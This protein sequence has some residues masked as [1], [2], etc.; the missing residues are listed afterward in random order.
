[1]PGLP[2]S[3]LF[4]VSMG[5]DAVCDCGAD[6]ETQYCLAYGKKD[7]SRLAAAAKDSR[8][9]GDKAPDVA[10]GSCIAGRIA[11]KNLFVMEVMKHS[12]IKW[13][14]VTD[15][16]KCEDCGEPILFGVHAHFHAAS[17]RAICGSC[18]VRRGWSDSKV[19]KDSVVIFEQKETLKALRRR[20]GLEKQEL[21]VLE[22]KKELHKIGE[23]Y[24]G[25]GAELAKSI[26][27][28]NSFVDSLATPQEKQVLVD[29]KGGVLFG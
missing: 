10:C 6:A 1:M 22:G 9:A 17:G 26:G 25:L 23:G 19:A 13:E 4:A 3:K 21:A 11:S 5:K 28:L 8:K 20:V 24:D 18:G 15:D 7:A 16:L 27:L 14:R 2:E 29:M 12:P